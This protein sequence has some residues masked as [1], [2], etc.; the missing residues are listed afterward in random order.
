MFQITKDKSKQYKINDYNHSKTKTNK[1]L[2]KT[3]EITFKNGT[4]TVDNEESSTLIEKEGI[5]NDTLS[6]IEAETTTI[7]ATE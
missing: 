1:S 2:N 7:F 3:A 6:D 5:R 4:K